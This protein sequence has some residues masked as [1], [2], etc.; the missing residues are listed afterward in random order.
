MLTDE[1]PLDASIACRGRILHGQLTV[2]SDAR[3]VVVFAHG[4]GSGRYSQRNQFVARQLQVAGFATL[5]LDLLDED[6]ARDRRN[7]FDIPLLA[8][9]L[10]CAIHWLAEHHAT[11]KLP[12]VLFGASTGA[13]AALVSAVQFPGVVRAVVSRGGRPDLAA[14]F[15]GQVT[16]PTLLIVGGNDEEVLKLNRHALQQLLAP[17]ELVVVPGATHLF[18]EP[19]ALAKVAQLAANWFLRYLADASEA[20]S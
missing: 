19:G 13:A 7:V 12:L 10:G 9:S 6:E 1:N 4:S 15:L 20:S 5:L 11:R 17:S 18:E 8:T 3:G 16:A 2:P 14:E